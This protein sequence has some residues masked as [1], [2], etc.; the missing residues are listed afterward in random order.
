MSGSGAEIVNGISVDST[1]PPV[2][3]MSDRFDR[4]RIFQIHTSP[5]FGLDYVGNG[6]I[7]RANMGRGYGVAIDETAGVM[8]VA[9]SANSTSTISATAAAA[10]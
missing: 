5:T 7:E 2:L 8:A 6:G 9:N 4:F 10:R 3:Y 1:S